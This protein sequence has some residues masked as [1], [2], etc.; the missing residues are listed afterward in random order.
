LDI[1]YAPGFFQT[2]FWEADCFPSS[3]MKVPTQFDPLKRASVKHGALKE[4]L[5]R[6]SL[7]LSRGLQLYKNIGTTPKFWA[8]EATIY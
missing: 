2:V 3:G 6:A 8:P 1:I 4:V 7:Q 5:T